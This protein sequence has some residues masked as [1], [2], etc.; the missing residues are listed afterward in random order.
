M[1]VCK[2]MYTHTNILGAKNTFSW[3]MDILIITLQ[4]PGKLSNSYC[5]GIRVLE[6]YL[7][8]RNIVGNRAFTKDFNLQVTHWRTDA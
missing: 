2:Y 3:W 4:N 6:Y 8:E 7:R 5:F 1:C